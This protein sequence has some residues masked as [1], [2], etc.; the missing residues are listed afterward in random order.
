MQKMAEQQ[1]L[2]SGRLSG[3]D[4]GGFVSTVA[5]SGRPVPSSRAGWAHGTGIYKSIVPLRSLART[6]AQACGVDRC[7]LFAWCEGFLL[8]V[9]SQFAS[10]HRRESLWRAFLSLGPYRLD[11]IPAFARAVTERR[12]ILVRDPRE[13][14]GLPAQWGATFGAG[15]ALVV[16][17]MRDAA[18]IGVAL[19]DNGSA[20]ITRDQIRRTRGLGPYLA[21]VIDSTLSLTELRGWA[22]APLPPL[23]SG[24]PGTSM[25]ELQAPVPP[26]SSGRPGTSMPELQETVRRITRLY[27]RAAEVAIYAERVR[28]DNLLHDTLRQTLF[29]LGFRIEAALR[30][31]Q[32][33]SAL[34]TFIRG[35]K[36]D[37]AAMMMQINQVVPT[38][39]TPAHAPWAELEAQ[40]GFGLRDT[41]RQ[42]PESGARGADDTRDL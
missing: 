37:I 35:F 15:S 18:I 28:V 9:M 39:G 42:F 14:L 17:L 40:I 4:A 3:G 27:A 36:Q 19:L 1:Y 26:L 6:T 7:S 16:P 33:A 31:P 32:R 29:T 24:R 13:E 23:T 22:A 41:V 21:S 2:S 11:E 38:R 30:G 12:P 5:V 10:G 8:P 20:D 25:P 34:R